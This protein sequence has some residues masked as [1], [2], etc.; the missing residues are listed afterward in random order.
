[1]P[2]FLIGLC[3]FANFALAQSDKLLG[4]TVLNERLEPEI[5][6]YL[7]QIV[8]AYA[9]LYMRCQDK[10]TSGTVRFYNSQQNLDIKI[11]NIALISLQEVLDNPSQRTSYTPYIS[12]DGGLTGPNSSDAISP[13]PD[14]VYLVLLET[15]V[16]I[17]NHAVVSFGDGETFLPCQAFYT[18]LGPDKLYFERAFS[19]V[20][21]QEVASI[22]NWSEAEFNFVIEE[23]GAERLLI[24]MTRD[25][26]FW[27]VGWPLEPFDFE[28]ALE[29]DEWTYQWHIP[30]GL[31]VHFA[32]GKVMSFT[33]WGLP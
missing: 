33:E 16:P 9:S 27:K 32:G 28:E 31:E 3:L 12:I 20:S 26:V 10:E 23:P 14:S 13:T 25:M 6:S 30:Y 1:V 7:G 15:D 29:A 5:S 8:W 17:T 24:G 22:Q 4:Y 19:K 11:D 18:F 2:R 21:L